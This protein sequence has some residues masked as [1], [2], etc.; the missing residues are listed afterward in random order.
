MTLEPRRREL[1]QATRRPTPALTW[2][3]WAQRRASEQTPANRRRGL[4]TGQRSD[5]GG[6]RGGNRWTRSPLNSE[7]QAPA[8]GT[9]PLLISWPHQVAGAHPGSRLVSTTPFAQSEPMV[10][11]ACRPSSLRAELWRGDRLPQRASLPAPRPA[12]Q[13]RSSIGVV[14]VATSSVGRASVP[15][16]AQTCRFNFLPA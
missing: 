15:H 12:S 5:L 16:V 1:R 2:Q 3:L 8:P 11:P 9:P 14:V 6:R 10:R 7:F 13:P 4:Y